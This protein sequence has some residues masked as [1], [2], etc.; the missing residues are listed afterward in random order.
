MQVFELT[1]LVVAGAAVV[2][3]VLGRCG[4]DRVRSSRIAV[5]AIG[6][7]AGVL[8]ALVVLALAEDLIPDDAEPVVGPVLIAVV[9]VILL[10]IAWNA[11]RR[12]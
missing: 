12:H 6:G 5:T 4:F 7:L 1:A 9:T 8:G 2:L 3:V 10:L 11:V